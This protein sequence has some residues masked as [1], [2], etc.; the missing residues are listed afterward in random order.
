MSSRRA[1]SP[2]HRELRPH[3]PKDPQLHRSSSDCMQRA[4]KRLPLPPTTGEF[5]PSHVSRKNRALRSLLTLF[6]F[7]TGEK[8]LTFSVKS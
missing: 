5:P 8:W 7:R 3:T 4:A 6:D 2:I 1:G